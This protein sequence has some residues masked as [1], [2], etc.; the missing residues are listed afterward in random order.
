MPQISTDSLPAQLR[1]VAV[2]YV[3]V[4]SASI[5]QLVRTP[6]NTYIARNL[7]NLSATELTQY[8]DVVEH[9]GELKSGIDSLRKDPNRFYAYIQTETAM[10]IE[11][12]DIIGE[13]HMIKRVLL[14][15]AEA[16]DLL[17]SEVL[18]EKTHGKLPQKHSSPLVARLEALQEAAERV[19]SMVCIKPRHVRSRFCS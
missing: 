4:F 1:K 6:K 3:K 11:V 10:L 7:A 8:V 16:Y 15:Q 17:K 9:F 2:S 13:I 14:D 12:G 19:R 18:R 5:N